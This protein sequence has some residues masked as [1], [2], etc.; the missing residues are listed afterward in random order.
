MAGPEN[1]KILH[2]GKLYSGISGKLSSGILG[3]VT[4]GTLV[5]FAAEWW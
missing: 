4:S 5:N 2:S 3:K 1:L